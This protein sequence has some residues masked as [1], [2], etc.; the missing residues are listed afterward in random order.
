MNFVLKN[1]R[2]ETLLPALENY[3]EHR[4]SLKTTHIERRT[5]QPGLKTKLNLQEAPI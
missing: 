1:I 5:L 3:P 2:T 4:G